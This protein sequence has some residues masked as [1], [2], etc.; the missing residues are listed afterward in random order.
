ML[1]KTMEKHGEKDWYLR[2]WLELK[3]MSQQR[4]H[5]LTG[6][7]VGKVNEI[8]HSQTPFRRES[9]NTLAEV[10]GVEPYELLM[11]PERAMWWR[12]IEQLIR[13]RPELLPPLDDPAA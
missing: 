3:N 10:L 8:Y 1:E 13:E 7:S 12:R 5:Q 11:P 2:E 4:I 6:C 9:L